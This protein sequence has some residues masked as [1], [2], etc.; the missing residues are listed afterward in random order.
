MKQLETASTPR[1]ATRSRRVTSVS[2]TRCVNHGMHGALLGQGGA[3]KLRADR[4]AQLVERQHRAITDRRAGPQLLVSMS[5]SA[6]PRALPVQPVVDSRRRGSHTRIAP[7]PR[8]NAASAGPPRSTAPG[9]APSGTAPSPGT[10]KSPAIAAVRPAPRARARRTPVQTR[11]AR[12]AI[13]SGLRATSA[14]GGD[15]PSRAVLGRAGIG[16]TFA[17]QARAAVERSAMPRKLR[18][19]LLDVAPW[20]SKNLLAGETGRRHSAPAL[21]VGLHRPAADPAR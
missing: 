19:A 1:A 20:T 8:W 17:A 18:E 12:S 10:R 11:A 6:K 15:E 7:S 16:W 4:A 13:R 5:P 3:V 21:H 2:A 9:H 14:P